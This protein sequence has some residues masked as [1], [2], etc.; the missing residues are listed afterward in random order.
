M[1]VAA[2]RGT[3]GPSTLKVSV[4]Y[5]DGYVGEGQISY[6]GPGA[7]ARGRL[8]LEIV[9]E[10]LQLT[11]VRCR[12]TRFDLIGVDACTAPRLSAAAAS[13]PYE[14]RARVGGRTDSLAR[15]RSASATRWRRSTPTAP[16][17]GA[18]RASRRARSSA[19]VSAFVPR[20]R[21][22]ASVEMPG[23]VAVQLRQ[24]A[25]TRTGDK[26]ETVNIS[27]I[28]YDPADY[29]SSSEH[30]TAE[31]VKEHFRGIVEGEVV[32]YELPRIG[33]L[34]FVLHDALWRRRHALA[35]ARRRTASRS[36]RALLGLELPSDGGGLTA[37]ARRG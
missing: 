23:G 17:A 1:R 4:G 34:N 31:R 20:E 22:L 18:A 35:G 37:P 30:V 19:V 5:R 36:P 6:A 15:T 14:V 27:V 3:R 13:E 12:E 25:H 7:V 2:R 33:A 32:R 28:A 26:G 29:R 9:A 16:P 24:L 21:V 11:G 10:R 8:A